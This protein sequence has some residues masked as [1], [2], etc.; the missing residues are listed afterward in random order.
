[1]FAQSFMNWIL[2]NLRKPLIRI[3]SHRVT[4]HSVE[5]R[6]YKH[7]TRLAGLFATSGYP[8]KASGRFFGGF[9]VDFPVVFD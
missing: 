6:L 8:G 9:G 3:A 7:P 4:G 1:M 5:K 2:L